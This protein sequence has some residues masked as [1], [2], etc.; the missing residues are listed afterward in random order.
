[1][2][3]IPGLGGVEDACHGLFQQT[4]TY[5]L[6]MTKE[7]SESFFF[8]FSLPSFLLFIY[9]STCF[10]ILI[11]FPLCCFPP[12]P[13]ARLFFFISLSLFP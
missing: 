4:L 2:E 9:F 10:S 7:N 1:L 6:G 3:L 11:V 5:S 12:L 13:F 8:I